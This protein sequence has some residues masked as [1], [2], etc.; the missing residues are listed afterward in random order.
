MNM[1]LLNKNNKAQTMSW[2]DYAT[3]SNINLKNLIQLIKE[4]VGEMTYTQDLIYISCAYGLNK[5]IK[6]WFSMGKKCGAYWEYTYYVLRRMAPLGWV[7]F[8]LKW[9]I[10]MFGSCW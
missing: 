8:L 7:I 3:G 5:I 4:D 10:K 1:E 9:I 6:T 2:I